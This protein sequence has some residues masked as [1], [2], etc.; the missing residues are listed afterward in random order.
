M[1]ARALE[2][3]LVPLAAIKKTQTA[4][5]SKKITGTI[6]LLLFYPSNLYRFG[7]RDR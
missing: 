5:L 6:T 4:A 7:G 1:D 3:F 2:F